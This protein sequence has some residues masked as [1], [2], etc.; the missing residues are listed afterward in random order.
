MFDND[1]D[2]R[3]NGFQPVTITVSRWIAC[4]SSGTS[5]CDLELNFFAI[6]ICNGETSDDF[7]YIELMLSVITVADWRPTILLADA[8]ETCN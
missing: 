4:I 7:A 1:D 5:D 6:P 8:A 3:F 2:I